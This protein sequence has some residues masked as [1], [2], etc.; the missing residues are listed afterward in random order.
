MVRAHRGAGNEVLSLH[1]DT[2]MSGRLAS[3]QS[4]LCVRGISRDSLRKL[5]VEPA[6]V[7][8]AAGAAA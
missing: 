2:R 3:S 4:P 5:I 1:L 6:R 8:Q 7:P